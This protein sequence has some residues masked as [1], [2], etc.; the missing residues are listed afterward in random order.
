MHRIRAKQANINGITEA[1]MI[2]VAA[3]W[4]KMESKASGKAKKLSSATK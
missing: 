1:V 4:K 3:E 2:E